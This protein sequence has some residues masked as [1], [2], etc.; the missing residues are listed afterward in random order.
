MGS[1]HEHEHAD[2]AAAIV[3]ALLLFVAVFGHWSYGFY[4]LLRVVICAISIY[5]AVRAN[6]A[7]SAP[8]TWVL[9]VMAVL[10]NPVLPI[11]MHRSNWR[12]VDA[13]AA[14]TFLVFVAA[15]KPRSYH[16]HT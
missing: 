5:L 1:D 4:T 15:Y 10:F 3:C 16:P 14:I 12:A 11:R 13:L 9:G 8:W 2:R 6:S 7:K